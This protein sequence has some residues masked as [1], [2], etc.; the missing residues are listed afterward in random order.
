[1]L[2]HSLPRKSRKKLPCDV[3]NTFAA[4]ASLFFMAA[5]QIIGQKMVIIMGVFW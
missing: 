3:F 2:I 4:H 1:M 5:I